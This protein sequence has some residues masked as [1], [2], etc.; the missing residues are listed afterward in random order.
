MKKLLPGYLNT[1]IVKSEIKRLE[2]FIGFLLAAVAL[3]LFM[4]IRHFNL[5]QDTFRNP[6]SFPLI[7]LTAALMIV[8]FTAGRKWVLKLQ[9]TD[10]RLPRTYF[11]YTV[12]MEVSIPALWLVV[13][14][15][16]EETSTLLDS[17]IIFVFFILIIVSSLH[18][19]F[20]LSACM[21]IL[22]SI[23]I[24]SYTYWVTETFPVKF[25]LPL[26]VYYIR[27]FMFLVSGI[28]AGLV[29]SE[30]RKR[31]ALTFQEIQAK[32]QIEGLFNQQV[33]KEMVEVLKEKQDFTA[34]LDVTIMFLD[35][36]DFTQKVQHLT[37]QE[38]NA[39]Q[40][41]FF[42]PVIEIINANNGIVNQIMGDG[43]MA[44]FGA[45]LKDA[46][47]YKS[48]W[49]ATLRILD[50]LKTFRE[51]NPEHSTLDIGMGMHCGEVLVGNIGTESRKQLSISGTPV[52][53]A[54]RIE[55]LN[56]EMESTVLMSKALFD[57]LADHIDQY[58]TKGMIKMK[59][60][61]KEVEI[62]K[63]F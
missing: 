20:W 33:S 30:L 38:V 1:E 6:F 28:C 63:V 43:L 54:S 14:S 31:L 3:A 8:L 17:P 60:L 18:L 15:L 55:Q 42:S 22:V 9:R 37:A 53:I 26:A 51:Q 4:Q 19:D 57:L 56:K 62:V 39:F 45:P 44:T 41:K 46:T 34:R 50:F 5:M 25:H 61:D 35:I 36:R 2:V 27:S 21:G 47:H 52:I 10:R 59:G 40:N 13:A 24:A 48:A 23:F 16:I 29:A 7:L 32:E 12:L 49:N 11:W 58:E